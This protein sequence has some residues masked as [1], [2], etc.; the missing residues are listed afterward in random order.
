MEERAK[1]YTDGRALQETTLA[2]IPRTIVNCNRLWQ[3]CSASLTDLELRLL[4]LSRES[5]QGADEGIVKQAESK[6][7]GVRG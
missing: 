1:E 5:L 3:R 6:Q 2:P 4:A 7:A